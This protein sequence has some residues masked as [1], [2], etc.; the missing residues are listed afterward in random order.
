MANGAFDVEKTLVE[1]FKLLHDEKVGNIDLK[2]LHEKIHALVDT[3]GGRSALCLSGGGI[4]SASFGL[5]VLQALA[6]RDLLFRFHYLSTV[7]GGGY[8]GGWLSA[9][10]R[11]LPD[12]V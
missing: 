7:S 8:I 11:R 1:E 5:G 12:R 10:R 6:R 9:W 4:R 3:G 2:T